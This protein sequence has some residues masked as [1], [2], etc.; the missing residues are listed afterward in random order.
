MPEKSETFVLEKLWIQVSLQRENWALAALFVYSPSKGLDEGLHFVLSGVYITRPASTIS[1]LTL[2]LSV[3][4]NISITGDLSVVN[5]VGM[6]RSELLCSNRKS[7]M[8]WKCQLCFFRLW[9]IRKWKLWASVHHRH[10]D[11]W[12]WWIWYWWFRLRHLYRRGKYQDFSLAL[13]FSL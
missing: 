1:R 8:N 11:W 13:L 3:Q 10:S 4:M 6:V 2:A 9:G 5:W 7:Y 12:W